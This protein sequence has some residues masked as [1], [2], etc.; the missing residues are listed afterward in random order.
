MCANSSLKVL[1]PRNLVM[2][3]LISGIWRIWWIV[4]L[5]SGSLTKIRET[6][7]LSSLEKWEGSG[8]YFP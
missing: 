3:G 8:M 1:S 5:W 6:N 2:R 7:A 4:G